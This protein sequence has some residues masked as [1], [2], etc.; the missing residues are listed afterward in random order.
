MIKLRFNPSAPAHWVLGGAILACSAQAETSDDGGTR[1]VRPGDTGGASSGIGGSSPGVTGGSFVGSPQGGTPGAQGG[2]PTAMGGV[3]SAG[4]ANGGT[5]G[6]QGGNRPTGGAMT[7]VGG[8]VTTTG[9][10]ANA[11]GAVG[12]GGA[13]SAVTCDAPWVVGNDGFVK[14]QGAGSSCW[15]GYAFTGK[16][17]ASTIMPEKFSQ[18]GAGCML[19]V[20]GTVAK[21]ADSSEVA[22][23]GFNINQSPGASATATAKPTG[24]GLTVSFTKSGTFPLRVQIQAKNATAAS[25][26]C[27]EITGTSPATIP[28]AM[29]NTE[30][31]EGGA[32]TAYNP[33][34]GEIEAVLLLVPGNTETDVAFSACLTGVKDG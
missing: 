13:A 1:P 33:A 22:F 25:R 24:T 3:G 14:A 10:I 18:C 12:S 27:A 15:H 7:A 2:S 31:W 11:G 28:Y 6:A 32:G 30:C 19:C 9:G 5:P 26:W 20:D 4:K 34:M 16:G 8:F 21:S 29:F 23:L 17:T